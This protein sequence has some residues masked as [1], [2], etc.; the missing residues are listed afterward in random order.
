MLHQEPPDPPS[1]DQLALLL[2][3]AGQAR[4]HRDLVERVAD[5]SLPD[6]ERGQLW[7]LEYAAHA[8]L[9]V[10]WTAGA[11][12]VS[13]MP[14]SEDPT[15][16]DAHTVVFARTPLHSAVGVWPSLEASVPTWVL[17]RCLGRLELEPL[18]ESRHSFRSQH[19]DA[20]NPPPSDRSWSDLSRYREELANRLEP[21]VALSWADEHP[22]V[23]GTTTLHDLLSS[24]D[25]DLRWLGSHLGIEEPHI[26]LLVWQ[27]RRPLNSHEAAMLATEL[28]VDP[29]DLRSISRNVPIRLRAQ[30]I[31][32]HY[33][34]QVQQWAS[35]HTLNEFDAREHIEER[36]M[37]VAARSTGDTIERWRALLEQILADE[38]GTR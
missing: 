36:V 10:V 32:P 37:A 35:L 30:T 17:D 24:R 31:R 11:T 27:G 9:A 18:S 1:P 2:A 5:T 3:T 38:L 34:P 33:R 21:F 19:E 13:V 20:G 12:A 29:A 23:E 4:V 8:A 16:Q 22:T 28:N 6:P 14:V 15:Y 25:L 7:R 26:A